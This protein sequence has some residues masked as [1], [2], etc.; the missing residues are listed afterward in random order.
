MKRKSKPQQGTTL[1][2]LHTL[3][4]TIGIAITIFLSLDLAGRSPEDPQNMIRPSL[5]MIL[6]GWFVLFLTHFCSHRFYIRREQQREQSYFASL[7]MQEDDAE[8]T[9][10]D[11]RRQILLNVKQRLIKAQHNEKSL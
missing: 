3:M 11:A 2:K 4:F 10:A 5:A 1:F 6:F 8:S 7:R 9:E